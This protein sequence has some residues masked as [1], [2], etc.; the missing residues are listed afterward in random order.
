[1]LEPTLAELSR[2]LAGGRVSSEELTR[3]CLARIEARGGE[4]NCVIT[5]M[6]EQALAEA[7]AADERRAAGKAEALTGI[8]LLHKDIFCTQG[9]RTSCGS[10]MLDNFTPPYDATVVSR[11][12]AAGAACLGKTNMDEFAMGSSCETSYYGPARNPWDTERV[13]GGSSGGSAAA[14][15]AGLA[16]GATGTDTGGSIRQPAALCGITGLK[17]TYG[18]VSRWGMIA[19]A[20]SLDQ[21]GPMARTAEDCALL[22]S[23]MAGYDEKD[24]TSAQQP[25]EDYAALLEQPGDAKQPLQSMKIGIIQS[26]LDDAR[27][28]GGIKAAVVDAMKTLEQL[29]A[30]LVDVALPHAQYGVPAYYVIAP[31]EASTNLA[32]YDGARYGYRCDAPK[33]LHD[34]YF[35]TRT[36]GFGAE[37]KRRILAGTYALAEG[38]IV[39]YYR[40]AQQ[41]R[42]LIQQDFIKAFETVDLLA[43]PT[44]PH[45]AWRIGEQQRQDD[46][47]AMYF[48]DVYTIPANLAGLP[49]MTVPA[50]FCKGGNSGDGGGLPAGLQLIGNY[51][52][53]AQLLRAAHCF[54]QATDWH[55]RSPPE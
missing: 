35:R 32:R 43:G 36:E 26:H 53:E 49:A 38:Y 1:M 24:S 2:E 19:F 25:A 27:L 39:E 12:R 18:R 52:A 9:A 55:L 31:A 7:R 51:F 15:A 46:P 30:T 41:A 44:T 29:G 20:S 23:A 8:P 10:K 50:G 16:P 14:V 5:A 22:L 4:L 33:D 37:V 48:E 13:P 42:R 6:P 17:P 40:K 45:P 47:L 21:G 11:L 34:L 28:D 3:D 54:Q